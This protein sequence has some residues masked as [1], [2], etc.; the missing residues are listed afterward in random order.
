MTVLCTAPRQNA[1]KPCVPLT[2]EFVSSACGCI[3]PKQVAFPAVFNDQL[4]KTFH[5][6]RGRLRHKAIGRLGYRRQEDDGREN[7]G[8]DVSPVGNL[9]KDPTQACTNKQNENWIEK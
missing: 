3:D 9:P 8:D 6:L 2:I 1:S 4:Q 5:V 7:K